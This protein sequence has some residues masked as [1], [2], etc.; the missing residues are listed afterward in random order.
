MHLRLSDKRQRD[1]LLAG[2][3]TAASLLQLSLGAGCP[4]P[5]G[6][7]LVVR[8]HD[9]RDRCLPA[10]VSTCAGLTAQS[11][12]ALDFYTWHNLAAGGWTIAWFC[13]L[14]GLAVWSTSRRFAA[15]AAFVGLTDLLP[16]GRDAG[17]ANWTPRPSA[18]RSAASP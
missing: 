7:R 17:P 18:S 2:V 1:W 12:A 4:A 16:V 3:L 9:L 6:A 13:A 14:Y 5:E 15:G 11:V 8:D 10:A